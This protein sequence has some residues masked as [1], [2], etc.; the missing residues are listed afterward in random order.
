MIYFFSIVIEYYR[1][2]SLSIDYPGRNMI[3]VRFTLIWLMWV[4]CYAAQS[5]TEPTTNIKAYYSLWRQLV[6]SLMDGFATSVFWS[7]EPF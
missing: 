2:S 5:N 4:S 7:S 6:N 1:F 3:S